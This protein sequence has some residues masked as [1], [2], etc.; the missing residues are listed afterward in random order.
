MIEN[1][2]RLLLAVLVALGL[3]L[4]FLGGVVMPFVAG[5]LVAYFL[6]PVVD[7][8]TAWGLSRTLATSIV[9]VLFFVVVGTAVALAIP[10]LNHQIVGLMESAPAKIERLREMAAPWLERFAV[11]LADP[12]IAQRMREAAGGMAQ[13]LLRWATEVLSSVWSGGLALLNLLS[14][15]IITPV[16]AFYL[17]R[18][19]DRFVHEVDHMLPRREAPTIRK[20]VV[21]MDSVLS[22]FIRGQAT[23]CL[24]LAI[25][26]GTA[27][28]LA[29][30]N[31]GLVVG[32]VTGALAFIPYVGALTG[33]SL[34]IGIALAQYGVAPQPLLIV[35]G[36]FAVGQV[37]EGAFLT[38]R[39]VGEKVGLH[40]VWVLFALMSGGAMFGFVG[41]LVAL[42]VAAVIA[43]LI[44]HSIRRYKQSAFYGGGEG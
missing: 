1:R 2:W 7:R 27:L 22:A 37:L 32:L 18:D 25:Y 38:P 5:I 40:P 36:I 8:M 21:D 16:V 42:P 17:L 44:R 29:G 14:L 11:G 6:D 43:V 12:E 4:Y 24:V 33:F 39:L 28:S 15:V 9:T 35:I 30:I 41:V 3:V 10:A 26:Y 13:S 34:G 20:L 23:V 31:F 19:Y